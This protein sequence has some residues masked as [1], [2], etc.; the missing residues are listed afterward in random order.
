MTRRFWI[1][2]VCLVLAGFLAA[3]T[4]A[5]PSA[6]AAKKARNKLST[7]VKTK[8]TYYDYR[9]TKGLSKAKFPHGQIVRESFEVPMST[10]EPNVPGEVN[11]YVEVVRPKPM[12]KYP[13]ILELSPYHG[14]LADRSGARIFPG[15]KYEGA[16]PAYL[17][18]P[19]SDK[20]LG[21]AGYFA[22]RG[23]AVVFA[24][25]RGTGKS[26]GCLDHLGPR[27]LA[28][29]KE[30]IDWI[31]KQPWSNGRV[32][33]TGHSYVGS[34]PS[35]AAAENPKALKT[36]VPSAGLAG[37]YH[38]KF[39]VGVPYFLQWVGPAEAYEQLAIQRYFLPQ[40]GD[41]YG[42]S[43]GE[44]LEWFGC[45]APNSAL[46]TGEA[47]ASGQYVDWDAERDHR[48]GATKSKIPVFAV[49][50]T[51]D[52]AARIP[53]LDWFHKRRRPYDKAWIGQ[54]DHGSNLY[55]NDRTCPQHVAAPCQND[56][57]TVALH[58]WFDK[59]LAQRKVKT[60]PRV[61]VF[62]NNKTVYQPKRWT[63]KAR[64]VKLFLNPE[65]VLSP[66][67]GE[68]ETTSMYVADAQGENDPFAT[69]NVQYQTAP[70]KKPVLLVGIPK[71]KLNA[72]IV[73]P[74]KT[75]H[76]IP[77]MYEVPK[78]G[79]PIPIS[80]ASFAINPELR[81]GI[82]T[83]TPVVPAEKMLLKMTGMAQAH[84]IPKGHR[85]MVL[86][87]SSHPD[88][89]AT[90]AEG[91]VTIYEGGAALKSSHVVLPVIKRAKVKKDTYVR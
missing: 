40:L 69:G 81:E 54:W 53:A 68:E 4:A 17:D 84:L 57:W 37:M 34:T 59:H 46:V 55:P 58:A 47:F 19:E 11:L 3:G 73:S 43:F 90:F 35:M 56:Q 39:Q 62:L 60:G 74:K 33:M 31:A 18:T 71:M 6:V 23:Y 26:G 13:T 1:H 78:E 67:F 5:P 80:K 20:T 88:K 52:N 48:K 24:D 82:D 42:D 44:N 85:I 91:S 25:L 75:T 30:L 70:M 16:R 2:T 66:K 14:T 87:A 61:E 28:D 72:S 45:G 83:I 32:G 77:T 8:G 63:P 10:P 89:V 79:D 12:A 65:G 29:S 76:I 49:H 7:R 27:D 38:H 51:H 64:R 41:E 36:I 86:I 9:K 15:P 50:G 21:L 22:P